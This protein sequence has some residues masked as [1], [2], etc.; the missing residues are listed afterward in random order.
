MWVSPQS[1]SQEWLDEFLALD[2]GRAA[3]LGGVVFG[4]QVR[5]SL[6]ELRKAV[7]AKYPIRDYPDITHSLRCQYPVPDWD[8]AYALTE[9][10]EVI[11][12]RPRD[13]AAIFHAFADQTIG[14]ITYSE[15]C[16]DDVNKIIWSAL[17][18]DPAA[19]VLDVLRDYARYL[20]GHA[21]RA[22]P[23]A[24][25]RAL[26]PGA[27]LARAAPDQQLGR[28]D[29]PAVPHAGAAGRSPRVLANWRFQ[30]ALYRAYYDAYVRS[31][32]IFETDLEEQAMA[33][34]RQASSIGSLAA[35]DQ[36][37]AIL[38]RAVAAAGRRRPARAG[39]RAGRGVVPEHPHA[40]ERPAL[41]GDR[42]G[43]RREPRHDRPGLEQPA[44]AQAAVRRRSASSTTEPARLTRD[45]RDRRLDEPRARRVL[46]RSRQ[47]AATAP[48]G[49]RLDLCGGPRLASTA[50]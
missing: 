32:L 24:S 39:L 31:R 35:M 46:R 6:P 20:V 44:L 18:W 5:V 37:E 42:R 2:E 13:E 48:P 16:N 43:P 33:R 9:G 15:G 10:R 50:R 19:D 11:N 28:D 47:P 17:G 49:P 3:W 21:R 26:G 41:Q 36:A 34:L 40:T 1:F 4:P 30:Q 14:F 25:P 23:T 8:V 29:A 7:P 38:D 22:T 45:R 27:K 12:P